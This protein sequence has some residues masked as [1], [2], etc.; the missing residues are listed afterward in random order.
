MYIPKYSE[1]QDPLILYDF[2][3]RN[4]FATL[5]TNEKTGLFANHLPLLLEKVNDTEVFLLGHLARANP[6][7][8]SFKEGKDTLIL[9]HGPHAYITPSLYVEKLNVPTWNYTAVHAHC[10][11]EIIEDP[12]K[13]EEILKKSVDFFERDNPKQWKYDLPEE[14][15]TSLIRAIAG[16]KFSIQKL[17][18]KFKLSQN[19]DSEDYKAV[20]SEFERRDAPNGRELARLMRIT[21]PG[22]TGKN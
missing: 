16:V 4:N 18:G 1:I 21:S 10:K 22:T 20:L 14:F 7:Y 19:R 6:H 9:F 11:P 12:E 15:R 5:I 2:M 3:E 8:R 17:E 13:I